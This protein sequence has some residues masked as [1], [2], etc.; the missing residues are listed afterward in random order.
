MGQADDSH[1]LGG[2]AIKPKGWDRKGMEA[3]KY[4]LYNPET[5]EVLT[6]T[7]LS[8]LKII[9]FYI[10]YY[11]FLAGFWAACLMIFFLTLPT[12]EQ[13]PKWTLDSS[14][15]GSNPGVGLRPRP[16]DQRIDS[17][18]FFLKESCSNMTSSEGG[19]GDLNIDY[20]VRMKN[21]I[22]KYYGTQDG[23]EELQ[24]CEENI[25]RNPGEPACKFDFEELGA[26]KDYPY[27]FVNQGED[28]HINPCIFLKLNKIY[29]WQPT[30]ILPENLEDDEY[31]DMTDELKEIIKN[32]E[33]PNQIWFDCEG[34]FAA[35]KEALDMTFFPATQGIP[36]KYFPFQGGRYEP[37]L[38]AVRLNLNE[39]TTTGQLIHVQC[40]AWFDG[41]EHATREKAGMVM[42]E[43]T[44]QKEYQAN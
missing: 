7:P 13:G 42:F 1:L 4:L 11:C 31:N 28:T 21:N 33:D 16:T 30:P 36:I 29:D 6:R 41:V 44:F 14:R 19:E 23:V 12:A 32:A 43:V 34:R 17:Q 39:K 37:P 2:T 10:V 40:K 24:L 20:A 18:M 26:C 15:I 38:V 35:D 27:G 25:L 3:F 5:G 22:E 8:W 9:V